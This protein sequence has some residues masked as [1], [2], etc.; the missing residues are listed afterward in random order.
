MILLVVYYVFAKFNSLTALIQLNSR[1]LSYR[2]KQII[3]KK[4]ITEKSFEYKK[5]NQ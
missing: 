5:T 3:T 2:Y 4:K 1:S